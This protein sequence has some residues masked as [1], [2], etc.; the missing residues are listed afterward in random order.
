LLVV[1]M[2]VAGRVAAFAD[3][4][5][6]QYH[7][8]QMLGQDVHT[9]SVAAAFKSIIGY[10]SCNVARRIHRKAIVAKHSGFVSAKPC[11]K[12]FDLNPDAEVLYLADEVFASST[13]ISSFGAQVLLDRKI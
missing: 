3:S 1:E 8:C 6:I 11:G 9:A 2:V 7:L 4:I 5:P 10:D 12:N 13:A